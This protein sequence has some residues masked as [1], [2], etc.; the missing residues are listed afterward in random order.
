MFPLQILF[1]CRRENR[2]DD[3]FGL[4]KAAGANFEADRASIT[5]TRNGAA[6]TV[7]HPEKRFFPLQRMPTSETA[8]Y[9]TLM[10]D[11][12]VALGDNDGKNGWT[13]RAY[14][15]PLVPW[16]WI[17]A[18]VMALGGVVS[19]SDRRWRVGVAARRTRGV[20]QAAGE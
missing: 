12:Y 2:L 3:V 16:I 9:T 15:K 18:V 20:P 5:V 11:L 1:V 7:M 19:L 13:V 17:G 14:W 8:I 6:V 4:R 10:A